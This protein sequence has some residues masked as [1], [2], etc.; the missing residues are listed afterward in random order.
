MFYCA[1][2]ASARPRLRRYSGYRNFTVRHD[3]PDPD[4]HRFDAD[5]DGVAYET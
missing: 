5:D 2:P 1:F 4:P 3:V